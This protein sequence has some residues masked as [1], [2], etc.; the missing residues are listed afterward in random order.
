MR[1]EDSE[2]RTDWREKGQAVWDVIGIFA[3]LG[4]SVLVFSLDTAISLV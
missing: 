2:E 1:E 4:Y 3:V